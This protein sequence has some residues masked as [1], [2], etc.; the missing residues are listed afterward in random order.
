MP[1]VFMP[2]KRSRGDGAHLGARFGEETRVGD[3]ADGQVQAAGSVS[4]LIQ[5]KMIGSETL[6]VG[7]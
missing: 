6:V 4:G 5:H 2:A 3:G 1:Q 7:R